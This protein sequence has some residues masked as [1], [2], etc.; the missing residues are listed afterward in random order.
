[1]W[2]PS[3][4]HTHPNPE[5]KQLGFPSNPRQRIQAGTRNGQPA[6][7][8]NQQF[9][10]NQLPKTQQAIQ[11][12]QLIC[13]VS[14]GL[15]HARIPQDKRR[16]AH[17]PFVPHRRRSCLTVRHSKKKMADSPRPGPQRGAC[18]GPERLR[19]FLR[20]LA[21]S[22][23]ERCR[24]SGLCTRRRP[25]DVAARPDAG[26]RSGT[27]GGRLLPPPRVLCSTTGV[28]EARGGRLR[29]ERPTGLWP[30]PHAPKGQ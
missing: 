22:R 10:T 12:T 14:K 30:P 7:F 24:L 3:R 8:R 17:S 18:R 6:F 27:R 1:M 28:G 25:D 5:F 26:S 9:L 11:T 19:E 29:Q 16:L 21:C 15:K 20:E 2:R 13:I 23:R 4:S